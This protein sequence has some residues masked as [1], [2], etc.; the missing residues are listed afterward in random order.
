MCMNP[1]NLRKIDRPIAS[2]VIAAKD[3]A[4]KPNDDLVQLRWFD[5]RELEDVA[6]V[7][8]GREFFI[9]AGYIKAKT[10]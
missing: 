2:V 10:A 5:E 6:L 3:L 9:Q 1:D 8:G 7:P 4:V